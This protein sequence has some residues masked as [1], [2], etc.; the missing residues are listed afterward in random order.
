M[1]VRHLQDLLPRVL[2]DHVRVVGSD[3]SLDVRDELVVGLTFDIRAARAM[4][5]L[6]SSLLD[7]WTHMTLLRLSPDRPT[8]QR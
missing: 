5:D 7:R 6:Q 3:V 8:E 2:A 4:D 1:G